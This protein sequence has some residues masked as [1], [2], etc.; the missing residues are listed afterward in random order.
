MIAARLPF[1]L[2]PL[3]A[4]AKSR[5]RRRR[6]LLTLLLLLAGA[7]VTALALGPSGS[8][9]STRPSGHSQAI[10]PLSQLRVPVDRSEREWRSKM[11]SISG[12]AS[13]PRSAA[14]LE[15]RVRSVAA[16]TGA[17]VVRIRI[18]RRNPH[19]GVEVVLAT[20]VPP[21]VYLRHRAQQLM[22]LSP[23]DH[24]VK[25]VDTR[26]TY[27]LTEW[28]APGA[29]SVGVRPALWRCSPFQPMTQL[30]NP[31]PCPVA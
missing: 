6:L 28:W 23:W 13:T 30:G 15:K 27:F 26:G 10:Q 11:R 12:P 22:E 29:G 8:P 1:A 25:V 16:S 19:P 18:W 9:A 24:Y 17:E 21:A 2:D 14:Q 7:G 4:E 31:P 3:I 5:M 20:R